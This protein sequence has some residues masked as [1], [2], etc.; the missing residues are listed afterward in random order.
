MQNS[1]TQEFTFK[2]RQPF[3]GFWHLTQGAF[4]S[5]VWLKTNGP[6]KFGSA[7]TQFTSRNI[8]TQMQQAMPPAMANKVSVNVLDMGAPGLFHTPQSNLGLYHEST[9]DLSSRLKATL[10]LRYDFMHTSIHYD[11]YAYMAMT[12]KVMGMEVTSKLRSMLDRK[13]GDD[14]NQ[15][16]P[17][18]GLSYKLDEQG[19]NVY[20]TVSKGYRAGGYN[21]QMFSDILQTDLKAHRQQAKGGNYDVPHTDK[22]YDRVNQ[23][24]AFKPETSWNYEVGTHL[25]LFDHRLHF[26]LSAFYMQVRNQQL[27]VMAGTYG[28]GRMMVNAGKSHSC[29]IEAALKG[30]AFDG[31]FDWGVNYGFTRAVFDEY[32][33]GEGD[34]AVNYK[35]KKVPYV[36]QHT[37][38]AMADYHLGQFT[39][40]LNMNAQG[41][42][43]WD[44]ANTYSQKM[45]FV[46]GA[47]CD[48]D[49]SKMSISIWGRNL[50]DTNYNTF[51]VDNA[52][53]GKK[54]YF[55]QRGNPFQC[56]IDL[57][58]HF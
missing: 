6:V 52:A 40:G 10:G 37:I 31:A 45:Y 15:L 46:M 21:I 3:F 47:H 44:N 39:F 7:L 36:P 22:D 27:S 26:D 11:T 56:G 5:H 18:F 48:I 20:A 2:S 32:T 51:A 16:L 30:Q 1:I 14:Y 42:T 8:L 12:V 24:I 58:F 28:F 53:T 17:K 33:D 13:T 55:A 41:K 43:Y 19:S 35:D 4:F 25:N 38:A 50:T 49:F 54:L 57:K 23:T 34:K 9:F 29:G